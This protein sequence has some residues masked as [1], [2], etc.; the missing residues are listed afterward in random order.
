MPFVTDSQTSQDIVEG[1]NTPVSVLP[2]FLAVP[3]P[4]NLPVGLLGRLH[5]TFGQD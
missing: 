2:L 5:F 1:E 4:S 3:S